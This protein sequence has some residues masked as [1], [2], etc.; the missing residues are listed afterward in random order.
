MVVAPP[1]K[2]GGCFISCGSFPENVR[3]SLHAAFLIIYRNCWAVGETLINE[4]I[5]GGTF[6][7]SE[8][9]QLPNKMMPVSYPPPPVLS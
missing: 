7:G 4:R 6:P 3:F 1:D 8:N 9:F 2:F 5:N